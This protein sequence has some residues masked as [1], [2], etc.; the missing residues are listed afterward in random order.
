MRYGRDA[1]SGCASV[2]AS[3]S[4]VVD[5]FAHLA[6]DHAFAIV[7]V[8]WIGSVALLVFAVRGYLA[9]RARERLA[10]TAVVE[11]SQREA[12]SVA[13]AFP[14]WYVGEP[15]DQ[16]LAEAAPGGIDAPPSLHNPRIAGL[17]T[18]DQR[19]GSTTSSTSQTRATAPEDLGTALRSRIAADP[20][21]S[22]GIAQLV[23]ALYLDQSNFRFE[24]IA[25]LSAD[26]RQLARQL[27]DA[28]LADP[29]A[30]EFWHAM[31]SAVDA[32]AA[33]ARTDQTA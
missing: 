10:Q 12:S 5:A 22:H 27:I 30:I 17:A 3:A 8:L 18:E 26:D 21:S 2:C 23:R 1:S 20:A 7:A 32:A 25:A 24:A 13:Q 28:W 4:D 14:D 33:P 9:A 11:P 6:M 31:Y 16:R 29:S 19:P 15:R